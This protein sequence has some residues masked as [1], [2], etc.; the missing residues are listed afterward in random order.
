MT[1]PYLETKHGVYRL[2]AEYALHP[3]LIV[4]FDF[5]DTVFDYHRQGHKYEKVPALLR[6]CKRLG[7][8]LV[9]LT[10]SDSEKFDAMRT[11]LAL[12]AIEI[13]AINENPIPL[14]FGHSGKPYFNILL[15]DR[16][17]LGQ[18][19]E[20]LSEVVEWVENQRKTA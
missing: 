16:A 3:R 17:G 18:A 9:L 15:D 6:R 7:F 5:D 11:I 13:D 10:A 19:V 1:D 20:I 4:A 2:L 12:E 8:Y 14:E